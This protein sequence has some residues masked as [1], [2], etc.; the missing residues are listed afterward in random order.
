[1]RIR[2][3][4][5]AAIAVSCLLTT[6]FAGGRAL[7]E[8]TVGDTTYRGV[9]VAHNNALCWLV[10]RDGELQRIELR[11]VTG[12]RTIAPRFRSMTTAELRDELRH[13]FGKHF[14]VAGKGCYLVCAPQRQARLYADLFDEIYRAFRSYFS[15][16]GFKM[17]EP[18]FPLVAVVFPTFEQYAKYSRSQGV[19]AAPGLAGY[20]LH[21][22]NRVALLDTGSVDVS[23]RSASPYSF[24]TTNSFSADRA[25]R[26]Y[27]DAFGPQCVA[28][29]LSMPSAQPFG[30]ITANLKATII[31]EATHQVAFN[32]G[33]HSRIGEN[34]K[35][36]VEGLATVFESTGIRN[37]ATQA[38]ARTRLNHERFVWFGDFAANRREPNSLARFVSSDALFRV[39]ALDAYAEAWALS[40]YLVETRPSE[41]AAYLKAIAERDPLARYSPEERLEDFKDAFSRDVDLLE[42]DFLR[43]FKKLN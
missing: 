14:D 17:P 35:W 26:E 16:R 12:Y 33:L 4:I 23:M 25:P 8:L 28:A 31:H 29:Y 34:P 21:T 13:E 2:D 32:T 36:V 37:A 20:Y 6:S 24:L 30:S 41:Y 9:S 10:G 19:V 7:I 40:F 42:A 22:S 11:D 15:R 3:W 38:S 1:M 5:L 27:V 18:E 39:S 43:F